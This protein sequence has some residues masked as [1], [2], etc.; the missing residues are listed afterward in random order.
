MIAVALNILTV[1]IYQAY[2]DRSFFIG[3]GVI[4]QSRYKAL[5]K[6]YAVRREPLVDESFVH[7]G[8]LLDNRNIYISGFLC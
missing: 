1:R 3:P 5:F 6:H 4:F 7:Y 8:I 2:R